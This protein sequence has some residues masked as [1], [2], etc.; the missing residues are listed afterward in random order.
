MKSPEGQSGLAA[1]P[2]TQRMPSRPGPRRGREGL[3]AFHPGSSRAPSPLL[4]GPPLPSPPSSLKC[5]WSFPPLLHCGLQSQ[6]GKVE[7]A[8]LSSTFIQILQGGALNS[9]YSEVL[10]FTS[11]MV[12]II[13]ASS[14]TTLFS[15]GGFY[16]HRFLCGR[17]RLFPS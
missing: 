2:Q 3:L 7:R 12:L 5:P 10:L 11:R 6:V 13:R 17:C 16:P 4:P 1:S 15:I 14:L 9:R 8:S